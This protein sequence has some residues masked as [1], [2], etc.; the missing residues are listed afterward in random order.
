L[1]VLAVFLT[2]VGCSASLHSEVVIHAP[3]ERVWSVLTDFA[4]YPEWNPFFVNAEGELVVGESLQ[5]TM[6]PVGKDQQSFSPELLALEPH[7]KLVWRGRLWIPWLFDG[8]HSFSIERIDARS[9]KLTQHE[10]FA[11]M[12]VPDVGTFSTQRNEVQGAGCLQ[13]IAARLRVPQVA[14]QALDPGSRLKLLR[15][16]VELSLWTERPSQRANFCSR[17]AGAGCPGA[18]RCHAALSA[19]FS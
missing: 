9:V 16:S 6:Q 10:D 7:R 2:L 4:E 5:L 17:V 14:S 19:H 8:T 1:V 12:F 13:R 15:G 11:G 18:A 3:P